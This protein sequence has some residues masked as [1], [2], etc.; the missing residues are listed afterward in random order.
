MLKAVNPT[1]WPVSPFLSQAVEASGAQRT[2][3]ISGQVGVGA[4]GKMAQ[5]VGA[6]TAAAI[7]NLN[8]VLDA[9]GM[10]ATNI[11]KMT[12]YLTDAAHVE[13]FIG[14]AAAALPQP[15]PAS[16]LLIIKGF[17]SPEMLVEIE[18]IAVA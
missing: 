14:A 15:P 9:A 10:N 11:A 8:T 1:G 17:P 6:Q 3:Y 7:A 12:I 13:A 18:A 2:L 4:D 16:S 5:G